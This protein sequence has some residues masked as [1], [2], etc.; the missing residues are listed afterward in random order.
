MHKENAP[1]C[2]TIWHYTEL[3]DKGIILMRGEFDK[4]VLDAKE[5]QCLVNQLQM[6]YGQDHENKQK[7][8]EIFTKHPEAFKHT[9]L[10]SELENLTL[11]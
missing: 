9:D 2:L 11:Q 6:Y 3:K 5:A 1:E 4:N 10:I 7:L 8:L